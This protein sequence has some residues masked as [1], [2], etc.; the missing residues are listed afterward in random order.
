[1]N[2]TTLH[3][4]LSL[5]V[6]LAIALS[7]TPLASGFTPGGYDLV[8]A[9]AV[10]GLERDGLLSE[11]TE[12]GPLQ[13]ERQ[14][15][16]TGADGREEQ[17]ADITDIDLQG[18]SGDGSDLANDLFIALRLGQAAPGSF[19]QQQ[20][21]QDFPADSSFSFLLHVVV[22]GDRLIANRSVAL[23]AVVN[24][25]LPLQSCYVPAEPVSV[26]TLAERQQ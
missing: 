4:R 18:R 21:G 10:F 2:T 14:D 16:M 6:S 12:A 5:T 9:K 23:T 20:A 8:D 17:T 3:S 25:I 15:P 24:K 11:L 7:L 19:R 13:I 22:G 1:M 26:H